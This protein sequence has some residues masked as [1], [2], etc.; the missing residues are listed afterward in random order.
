MKKLTL[1]MQGLAV[2]AAVFLTA[3][4]LAVRLVGLKREGAGASTAAV[5]PQ[6]SSDARY[7][8]IG[9]PVLTDIWVDPA[10]GSDN[11]SGRTRSEAL[12][13]I[14][15]A[16]NR[17][18]Q[19]RTLDASGFRIMLAPGTYPSSSSP[20][21]WES[22]YGTY[23]FPIVVQASDGAGTVGLSSMNVFDCRYLYLIGLK[24]EANGGDVLHFEK[25]DHVLVKQ[26]EIKGVGEIAANGGPQETLK[27][28]QCQN[29][30]V[31]DSDISGAWDNAVDFVAVQ[32]GHIV[33]NRIHR[34]HDWCIY[35]KGGSAYFRVEANEIF[36]GGTGGFT[37]GQGT[38]FQWM[39]PPWL[40]YEAYD[41]KVFNNVI[42]DTE[43]AGLG[44]Q[45]GYNILMAYNT[46][47]RVGRRSHL[48]GAGFGERSCDG[49]PG[50]GGRSRCGDYLA[51]GGWGT[52]AVDDGTNFTRVPNRNVF[53]YNNII[54][55]PRGYQSQ[56]Q[57][58]AI[59]GSYSGPAQVDSNAPSPAL[60]DENLQIRGNIIW[61]GPSTHPLGVEDSDSGCRPGN[62]A[63]NE[64]RLRAENSIN[65]IEPQ[66][67]NPGAG[68]Y[69]PA[70]AGNI[71]SFQ[72]PVIADF[73]WSDAPARPAVP[74]GNLSNLIN[75]DRDGLPRGSAGPPGA[76]T[77]ATSQ[78]VGPRVLS[79]SIEG[80]NL[81]VFGDGFSAGAV[82]VIDGVDQK[83][84]NDAD[85]PALILIAKKAGKRIAPGQSVTLQVRNSN[86]VLSNL[87]VFKRQ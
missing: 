87:F 64:A 21:Y 47:Y 79:A 85:N 68:D 12:R 69:H 11:Q 34:S 61:N 56:W 18:P 60:S 66:L 86:G 36:D 75:R 25:C 72:S 20:N 82:V 32:Y 41:I 16:W 5:S 15:A 37:A 65:I 13:T 46:L 80:R 19:N 42:H 29:V 51:G 6:T 63:C 59:S 7:Y 31:E 35:L 44:V 57:Q 74:G 30:Y 26:T 4:L 48:I 55:N 83:S 23:Q 45:G 84:M 3:L 49:Q 67:V 40:H 70:P 33:G 1:T 28:N 53:I 52:T 71:L 39:T 50:D 58:F 17:V 77:V 10:G 9:A 38:G 62:S 27:V 81:Y 54:Y 8:D 78:P 76:F 24:L 73:M 22:R 14:T 2:L 43:G